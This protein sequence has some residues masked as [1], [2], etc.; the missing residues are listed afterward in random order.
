MT[1]ILPYIIL[2][3]VLAAGCASVS[4]LRRMDQFEQTAH[5][6]EL[7]IRWSDFERAS[8]FLKD[9]ENPAL[10]AQIAHLMQYQVTA[11]EVKQF[12]PS[13]DKSQVIVFA[14]VQ[15][16]KKS[17]LIVKNFSHRQL[18][19]YDNEAENWFLISGLPDLK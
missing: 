12:L 8:A 1:K 9:Q 11:Y 6:Y 15:Y 19:K 17:G 2:I 3:A 7:A 5:A 4:K 16:F 14:N 18:W 10:P 13:A